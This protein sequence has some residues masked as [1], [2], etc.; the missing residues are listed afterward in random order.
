MIVGKFI[1]AAAANGAA[2]TSYSNDVFSSFLYT[3]NGSTQTITNGI[4]LLGSGGMVWIKRRDSTESNFVFDT[5]RG[6]NVEINSDTSEGNAT[7]SNSLTGFSGNGFS[8]GSAAS[9]VNTNAG[10]YSSWTFRKAIRFFD[11]VTYTGNGTDG[12]TLTHNLGQVPGFVI[13]KR[14]DAAGNWVVWH[15]SL[16]GSYPSAMN[17]L[18]L[19]S[20]GAQGTASQPFAQD[21]T[22]AFLTLSSSVTSNSSNSTYV[23][24]LFSHDTNVDGLI[25]CGSYTGNGQSSDGPIVTLGWEPQWIMVKRASGSTGDWIVFD[26]MR[27]IT[28]LGND[29]VLLANTSGAETSANYLS[30]SATGFQIF[31]NSPSINASGDT[32]VY[33]A[34]RCPNKTPTSGTDVFRPTAY[35]GT[36]GNNRLVITNIATDMVF[37]RQRNDT[38]LGG[39]LVGDRLRGQAY[40]LTGSTAAEVTSATAFDQ[41]I[42]S[43]TEYGTAFSAMNGFFVGTDA[44][45]KLNVD[46][47]A[48][49]HIVEA[50]KRAPG[51]FDVV[52]YRGNG[53]NNRNISHSLSV[54]PEF[55]IVKNRGG[56]NPFFVSSSWY[57]GFVNGLDLTSTLVDS[58]SNGSGYTKSPSCG[59]ASFFQVSTNSASGLGVDFS[60]VGKSGGNTVSA[61]SSS[62]DYVAYL[63]A[64]LSGISKVGRYTGNGSSQ[65]INCNFAAGAR[66]VLIKR[67]DSAG[68]WYVWDTARGIAASNDPHLS[69]NATA[70]EVTTDDSI[71]PY[72]AGFTVNQLAATNINVLNAT[73]IFL[74]IS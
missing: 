29:P 35:T 3:G 63:F 72:S 68:D 9:A 33:I 69:L 42:V 10:I 18:L 59:T 2:G 23:A 24:Y 4:N 41:Q 55:V 43:T 5:Q 11:V 64:S 15:R 17:Y 62:A 12:R 51:F 49:N 61:N 50:F 58:S 73:Y 65:S 6:I 1:E 45:A 27:G 14:T 30:S 67:T 31:N 13:I 40:L 39:M 22:N 54:P 34:I 57:G 25:Q 70:A 28:S 7:L 16:T 36:N 46:T 32:Y 26:S 71:D 53:T 52:C 20:A 37:V 44:T 21:P 38:S 66:F 74:S 8:V 19:N 56:I 48:S 47:S 60:I